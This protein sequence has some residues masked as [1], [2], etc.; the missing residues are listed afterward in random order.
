[1]SRLRG[2]CP[3]LAFLAGCSAVALKKY[4]ESLESV[5][6]FELLRDLKLIDSV[7]PWYSPVQPKS[8]F[9]NEDV[10]A[11]WDIPM[12]AG[13]S[14]SKGQKSKRKDSRSSSKD[15]NNSGNELPLETE[16]R[17]ER[18]VEAVEV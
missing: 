14:W 11:Y 3:E 8:L 9:E 2:K 4:Q 10:Q 7:P 6:F 12:F 17:E 13:I 5:I 18:Q 15:S 1:M 16:S